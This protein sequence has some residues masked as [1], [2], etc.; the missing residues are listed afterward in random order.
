MYYFQSIIIGTC[1]N[2][3]MRFTYTYDTSSI[4]EGNTA[5]EVYLRK[6]AKKECDTFQVIGF[7]HISLTLSKYTL[8]TTGVDPDA[9]EDVSEVTLEEE[10][11]NNEENNEIQ[12]E[13]IP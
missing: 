8:F 12:N 6:L 13:E 9:I 11:L 5:A 2:T 3:P 4:S 1:G 10:Q 7:E